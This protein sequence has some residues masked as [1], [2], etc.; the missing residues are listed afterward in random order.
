MIFAR[1]STN[2]DNTNTSDCDAT[3]SV[4]TFDTPSYDCVCAF[5]PVVQCPA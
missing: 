1:A 5:D 2:S 4:C 3:G